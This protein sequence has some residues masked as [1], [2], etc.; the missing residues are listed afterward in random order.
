MS[1]L[2]ETGHEHHER[3]REHID[4]LPGL[5]DMLEQRP[6][7]EE[8]APL[9]AAECDFMTGTLMPHVRTV[10][11]NVYPELERLQQNRHAMAHLRR[12][13][14]EM[15]EIIGEMSKYKERVEAGGMKPTV[16]L[17]MRRLC[18]RFYALTK[19]HIGEEEEYLRVLQG[20]LS[21][22]EQTAVEKGLEHASAE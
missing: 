5:A 19:T 10:E 1:P 9:F 17:E 16:A 20:N 6:V 12:E 8:F 21:E 13:H 22:G 11:E 14:E 15:A 7:P 2:P 18:I 4:R 3:I